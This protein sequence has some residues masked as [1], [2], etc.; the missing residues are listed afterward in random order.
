MKIPVTAL[1]LHCATA[2]LAQPDA[3][4][5]VDDWL[6]RGQASERT[7]ELDAALEAYGRAS[8]ADPGDWR[9]YLLRGQVRFRRGDVAGSLTDFD[10]VVARAP[11]REPFLWQRGISQFYAGRYDACRRQFELHRTVNPD[12]VENAAW[13]FLCVAA[14]DGIAEARRRLLPVGPDPRPPMTAVYDLYRG[15][16][17]V[18]DVLAKGGVA[19]PG[20]GFGD[21]GAAFYAHLY[22]GLYL[23]A[24][25]RTDL[26]LPHVEAAAG[27]DFPHYMGDVA[28]VHL[29][30]LRSGTEEP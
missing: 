23:E 14:E 3:P 25:D 9:P 17:R 19:A 18:D 1:V 16:A 8:Q 7:G 6:R 5:S 26:A 22:V 11:D 13:H 27:L 24:I 4:G 15:K 20:P 21:D 30:R 2:V 12:D 10:A 28:V 29:T